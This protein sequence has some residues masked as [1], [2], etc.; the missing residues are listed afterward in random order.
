MCV[1]L[2][3]AI[4]LS[5]IWFKIS[6][7]LCSGDFSPVGF[8]VGGA[9]NLGSLILDVLRWGGEGA[10]HQRW[11]GSLYKLK[12]KSLV[13]ELLL[14]D[15]FSRPREDKLAG[16][17][18]EFAPLMIWIAWRCTS[19]KSFSCSPLLMGPKLDRHIQGQIWF[20]NSQEYVYLMGIWWYNI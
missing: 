14:S 6:V 18:V 20:L 11:C 3:L 19:S 13:R 15:N 17:E 12:A 9:W 10:N 2:D 4:S 8:R 16:Y 5:D 1:A 7:Y